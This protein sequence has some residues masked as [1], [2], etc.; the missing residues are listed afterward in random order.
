METFS[1]RKVVNKV[2]FLPQKCAH[3]HDK[4]TSES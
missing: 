3:I 4:I 2:A 1:L